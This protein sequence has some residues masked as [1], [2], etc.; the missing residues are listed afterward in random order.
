MRVLVRGVRPLL[1]PLLVPR[2]RSLASFYDD[3]F[4]EDAM[5]IPPSVTFQDLFTYDPRSPKMTVESLIKSAQ[6][7]QNSLPQRVA[8]RIN[9]MNHLPYGVMIHPLMQQVYNYYRSTY[10]TLVQFPLVTNADLEDRF[11]ELL[12]SILQEGQTMLPLLAKA[13]KEI[14]HHMD[15]DVLRRFLDYHLQSRI[16][17]RLLAEQHVAIHNQFKSEPSNDYIGVISLKCDAE[18]IARKAFQFAQRICREHYGCAPSIEFSHPKALQPFPYIPLFLEYVLLEIFKNAVRATVENTPAAARQH[19]LPRVRVSIF[20]VQDEVT[21]KIHDQGGGIPSDKL[22]DVW[23]YAY[24][25]IAEQ[26]Q[27]ETQEDGLHT[28]VM[29]G[30]S[31]AGEGFGLPMARV[32]C[33]YFGGDLEMSSIFGFGSEVTI[34][35]KVMDSVPPA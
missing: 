6:R 25:T 10:V 24:T 16:S 8:R 35:L 23:E 17:R 11:S 22:P 30:K 3:R 1:S 20:Q 26:P 29:S 4:L 32:Y 9:D 18:K 33:R 31:M 12:P 14:S 28:Y 2:V 7:V 34:R 13:A 19:P 15:R 27:A 5:K 21:I